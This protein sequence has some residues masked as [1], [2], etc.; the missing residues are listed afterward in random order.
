MACDLSGKVIIITGTSSGIGA[1]TALACAEAGMDV[2]LTARRA[3]RLEAIAEQIT[4]LGR[5][6][7][8]IVGDITDPGLSQRLLDETDTHLG[9]FHAVLANAGHAMT[10]KIIDHRDEEVRQMFEV[11]FFAA[12]ELLQ[13][14]AKRLLAAGRPGHLLMTSSC[15]SKFSLPK[16]GIYAATK[17]AQDAVCASMRHELHG[18]S[19]AVSSVHPI[20]TTTEFFQVAATLS[21]RDP[22]RATLPDHSPGLF[23]QPPERVAK[24]IVKCLRRPRPEVWT[25]HIVRTVAG[26]ATIFPR[27]GDYVIRK[28]SG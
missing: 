27:F 14:A 7:H 17:A 28:R 25:S 16:H 5:R 13:L 18:T 4:Q 19:I 12:L 15:L 3:E 21:D 24:A 6:A 9:G 2:L 8:C 23:I 10:R 22:T 20:T 26:V 1:A 11:N